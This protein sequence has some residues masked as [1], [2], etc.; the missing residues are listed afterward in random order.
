LSS[1]GGMGGVR[2]FSYIGRPD[3]GMFS[4]R[5]AQFCLVGARYMTTRRLYSS[6][7]FLSV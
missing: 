7:E 2:N 5:T 4:K 1:Q 3:G 6:C